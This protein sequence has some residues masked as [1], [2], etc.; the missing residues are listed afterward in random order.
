MDKLTK[1]ILD[2]QPPRIKAA[3]VPNA[4][5]DERMQDK[6]LDKIE[7]D[8]DKS[9]DQTLTATKKIGSMPAMESKFD[10]LTLILLEKNCGEG[11]TWNSLTNK[12]TENPPYDE[13]ND[14]ETFG[15]F[16]GRREQT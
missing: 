2:Q 7:K 12:C 6:S 10:K 15:I 3:N 8:I 13:E 11:K 16:S 14:E 4:S 1:Y 9:K 5:P